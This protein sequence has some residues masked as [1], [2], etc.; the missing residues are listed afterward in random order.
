MFGGFD[1]YIYGELF[2]G[3]ADDIR[4][5]NNIT[6]TWL[7]RYYGTEWGYLFLNWIIG[8]ITR[9]RYIFITLITF[10]IY[11]NYY[12]AFKR[13]ITNY[14]FALVMFL[15]FTFYFTFTY[16]RQMIGV[17]VA[18]LAI[19]YLIEKDRKKFFLIML[20]VLML[21]KSGIIFAVVYLLPNKLFSRKIILGYL[22]VCLLIGVSGI[23]SDVYDTY[24]ALSGMG[25]MVGTNEYNAGGVARIA[26]LLEVAFFAGYILW[27]YNNIE[28]TRENIIFTN[29]ALLFCGTLL[30]FI[31]SSDG[32]RV[33]WYYIFGV[34]YIITYLATSKG[35]KI[36]AK[37]SIIVSYRRKPA[38]KYVYGMLIIFIVLYFRVFFSWQVVMNLY[39]YKTY[40]TNG[41]R[42]GDPVYDQYEYDSNYDVDKFYRLW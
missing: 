18:V 14:P 9:N 20:A 40:F 7:Y 33:A 24:E 31:R 6:D 37:S 39:P 25:D 21:H 8:L 13:H 23:I 15:T 19:K 28:Q 42:L 26:Y 36:D 16:L 11:Y 35:S 22:A 29:M 32:G 30:I 17:S 41:H 5:G 38:D 4:A 1:R 34:F 27:K 10:I 3:F 2:D 12:V